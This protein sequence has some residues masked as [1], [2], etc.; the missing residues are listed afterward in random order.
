M[1]FVPHVVAW[2]RQNCTYLLKS[3][4]LLYYTANWLHILVVEENYHTSYTM[5]YSRFC[6]KFPLCT[7]IFLFRCHYT[8][9]SIST[10]GQSHPQTMRSEKSVQ[11][12]NALIGGKPRDLHE[13]QHYSLECHPR[14]HDTTHLLCLQKRGWIHLSELESLQ[15][16]M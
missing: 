15:R 4:N 13:C 3:S 5:R 11:L 8:V 16:N 6:P 10:M 12:L 7:E 14:L 2:A 1:E 9:F